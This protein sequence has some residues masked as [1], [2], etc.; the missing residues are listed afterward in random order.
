MVKV[1]S[2]TRIA[3]FGALLYASQLALSFLPNIEIITLLIVLFTRH[4]GKE[5]TFACF[6]YALLT[7]FTWGFG[8]W[9]LTYLIVWPLFSLLVYKLRKNDSWII[10]AIIN[11]VFGLCFGAIF[12]LPYVFVSPS[13]ALSYWISGIPFDLTH[14]AGNFVA[15]ITLGKPLDLALGK[16][17]RLVDDLPERNKR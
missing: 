11:A 4:F 10:W 13:Y 17:K 1:Q 15:A 14:C 12:A 5:G 16:I 8:I 2:I 6:V 3:L 7:A 9:W